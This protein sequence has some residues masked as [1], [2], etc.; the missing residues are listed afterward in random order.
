MIRAIIPAGLVLRII[1]VA[2]VTSPSTGPVPFVTRVSDSIG[3]F[4]TRDSQTHGI[5]NSTRGLTGR[6]FAVLVLGHRLLGLGQLCKG[7]LKSST[8]HAHDS[9][10][11]R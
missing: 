9:F 2:F 5:G 4:D 1:G 6:T 7:A 10:I 8:D 3:F 11:G